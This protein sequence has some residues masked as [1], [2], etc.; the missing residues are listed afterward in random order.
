MSSENKIVLIGWDGADWNHINPL[1]DQGLMPNL[2]SL[3]ENGVMGNIET[4][5]PVLSPM[6]WNSIATGKYGDEHGILGFSEPNPSGRGIRPFASTTRKCKALWNILSQSGMSSNIVNWWASF[7]SE[8]IDGCIVSNDFINAPSRQKGFAFQAGTFHPPELKEHIGPLRVAMQE[9]DPSAILPFIPKAAEIDQSTDRRLGMFIKN[10]AECASIQAAATWL[11]ENRPATL[12]AMYFEGIDHFCHGFMHFAPPRLPNV[13]EELYEIYKGVIDGA[14]R[15]HDM[16]LGAVMRMIDDDTWLMLCS[17]HGFQSGATRPRSVPNEPAGPAYWHRPLGIFALRGPGIRKDHRI[18]GASLLD[19]APTVLTLL[20]LPIGQDMPGKVLADA[21]ETP[22]EVEHIPSWENVEGES[23]MHPAD[24][25]WENEQSEELIE[26]FVQLGYIEDPGEDQEVAAERSRVE[27]QYNLA[28]V[29]LSRNFPDK[30]LPIFKQLVEEYPWE[31]RFL[32]HLARCQF[33]CGYFEQTRRLL[34]NAFPDREKT[35]AAVLV[36]MGRV[37]NRLGNSKSGMERLLRATKISP[38]L[39]GVNLELGRA[40]LH[41]REFEKVIQCCHKELDRYPEC[42]LSMQVAGV[43]SFKSGEY[44]QAIDLLLDSAA[45]RFRNSTVHYYLGASFA[46]I[47]QKENAVQAFQHAVRLQPNLVSAHRYLY[48]LHRETG[49]Q[50][51][52]DFHLQQSIMRRVVSRKSKADLQNRMH[53]TWELP[54]IP[55][56]AERNRILNEKRPKDKDKKSEQKP[57]GKT[58][59]LVSGLPRSGTSLMMQML[60]AGGLPPMTD[61]E[62]RADEDNPEGYLE[63]EAIKQIK[64][65]PELLDQDEVESKAIKAISMLLPQLPTHHQYKVIFMER[66]IAEVVESQFKMI[67]RSQASKSNEAIDQ[68]EEAKHRRKMADELNRHR[69]NVRQWLFKSNQFSILPISY[70]D[71]IAEPESQ[72]NQLVEFLGKERLPSHHRMKEVIRADLYRN[73]KTIA[74]RF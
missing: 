45:I 50:E 71:L 41:M 74:D 48:R 7:P 12:N 16:M 47:G 29:H 72:V 64:K 33:E 35:S 40:W 31:R 9:V 22:P 27:I 67:V 4:L 15:F 20:G 69:N 8:P 30:A 73:R 10:L 26:Q 42:P 37:E 68:D 46:A 65:R 66:P 70:N 11:I 1:L 59:V 60:S 56:F 21:F 44:Q 51:K 38:E 32:L 13:P 58:F 24:T 54:E 19:I 61:G 6:L 53:E 23:G 5:V 52:S 36:L 18:Y 17:D 25:V 63:W 2:Q 62:R 57:S 14:Y 43:A 3:I 49:D 28:R 39:R 34:A 55:S